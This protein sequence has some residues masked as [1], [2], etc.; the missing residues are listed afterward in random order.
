MTRNKIDYSNTIIYKIVCNDLSVTEIYIGHTTKFRQRKCHH[1]SACISSNSKDY[2]YPLYKFIREH[3]GWENFSMIEI[4]KYACNDGN[5]AR[6]R[7]RFYFDL[8]NANLNKVRPLTTKEERKQIKKEYKQTEHCKEY[9]KEYSK[10]YREDNK[11]IQNAKNKI[12]R[13][14]NKEIIQERKSEKITCSCGSLITRHNKTRH[15]K[16]FKHISRTQAL[17]QSSDE[18][19]NA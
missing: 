7:E 4:E 9:N 16:S 18:I 17:F 6:A 5:E 1:K 11:D 14:E 2:N 19:K 8:L 13:E 10:K 12:Y 15:E 3:N